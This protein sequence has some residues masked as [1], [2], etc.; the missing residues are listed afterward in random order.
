VFSYVGDRF[1]SILNG[2]A[3]AVA[4]AFMS[5]GFPALVAATT[6]WVLSSGYAILMGQGATDVRTWVWRAGRLVAIDALIGTTAFYTSRLVPAIDGT[7][8]DLAQAMLPNSASIAPMSRS[9]WGLID[10]VQVAINGFAAAIQTDAGTGGWMFHLD[11]MAAWILVAIAA[12]VMEFV[13]A[14]VVLIAKLGEALYLAVGPVFIA[15]AMFDSTTRFFWAWVSC[16]VSAVAT[17]AVAFFLVG[18]IIY[19]GENAI[20][21]TVN[22]QGLIWPAINIFAQAV[23]LCG[24]LFLLA[25]IAW[26]APALGGALTGGPAMQQGGGLVKDVLLYARYGTSRQPTPMGPVGSLRPSGSFGRA[27]AGY[28]ARATTTAGRFG[29]SGVRWA[30]Q[31]AASAARGR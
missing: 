23:G 15:L 5:Y 12:A 16:V 6:L 2:Y 8:Y 11:L 3:T 18:L 24:V 22:Q 9:P 14:Y 25:V 17:M 19:F 28:A 30:Y 26:Q 10:Q 7:M 31:R 13:C 29:M 1:D 20:A 4:S 21:S 27:V